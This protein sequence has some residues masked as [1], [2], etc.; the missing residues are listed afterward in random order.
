MN[1]II[2]NDIQILNVRTGK[3]SPGNILVE[4]KKN[5]RNI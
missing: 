2:I 4:E 3:Y 1:K 5:K